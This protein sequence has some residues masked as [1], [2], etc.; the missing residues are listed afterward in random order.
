MTAVRRRA[1][2][3][4]CSGH[5]VERGKWIWRLPLADIP[6]SVFSTLGP[7]LKR[8]MREQNR[9]FWVFDRIHSRV[10]VPTCQV[11]GWYDRLLGTI[12][13]FT[14]MVANGPA[15]VRGQHRITIGPWE[16][17]ER[18]LDQSN[19]SLFRRGA[20][21]L[22]SSDPRECFSKPFRC[23][24]EMLRQFGE[25]AQRRSFELADPKPEPAEFVQ[26][27]R[28]SRVYNR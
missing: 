21:D 27:R 1:P 22:R 11:T 2:R 4:T 15:A 8:Y 9:E 14:G 5:E 13:N 20:A 12:D 23:D 3:R 10:E 7:M 28:W 16:C 18:Q 25:F 19:L 24:L 17:P 6:D 26:P